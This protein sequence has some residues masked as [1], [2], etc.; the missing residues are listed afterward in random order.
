MPQSANKVRYAV[1]GG[2][3]F[4]QTAVLPAFRNASENSQLVALVSGDPRKHRELGEQYQI[5]TYDYA[6]YDALLSSGSVDAVYIALPNAMHHDYTVRAA[7]AGV[8]VLCEKPMANTARQCQE[9]IEACKAA[10]VRLM[11][12]YRLHFEE[13][14]LKAIELLR[15]GKIGEPRLFHSTFTQQVEEGNVRLEAEQGGGPL[16][17]IGIYC[18]NA[19]R[20]LFQDEPTEAY[21]YG[22]QGKD[23]RFQQVPDMV[24]AVLRFPNERLATFVCGFGEAQVGTFQVVG[25]DGDLRMDPAFSFDGELRQYVTVGGKTTAERFPPRDQIGPEI[26]YFSRCILENREPEP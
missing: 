16:R 7:R 11:I 15:Q 22:I 8:H 3:W 19:A 14:N 13:G 20:Y 1:V 17:D 26:V 5:A 23:S 18:I 24:A 9:M 6:Q 2:G 4:A 10:R 21:A 25:T 12:A